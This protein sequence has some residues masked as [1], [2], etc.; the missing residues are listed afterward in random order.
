MDFRHFDEPE[1]GTSHLNGLKNRILN[2]IL[3]ATIPLGILS[4]VFAY[5]RDSKRVF[6]L[7]TE[8]ALENL[9]II[10]FFIFVFLIR[11]KIG[12]ELKIAIISALLFLYGLRALFHIGSLSTP[13]ILISIS[14]LV[15]QLN[16]G[17]KWLLIAFSLAVFLIILISTGILNHDVYSTIDYNLILGSKMHWATDIT[18][19]VFLGGV[20]IFGIGSY[21]DEIKNILNLINLKNRE[22]K[23]EIDQR[24]K[25]E[26]ELAITSRKYR[27]LFESS[28]DGVILLDSDLKILEANHVVYEAIGYTSE[29]VG[30][31]NI[32]DFID[33][34]YRAAMISRFY[35]LL[36]GERQPLTQ[37]VFISKS[38]EKV[39]IEIS[40]NLIIGDNG[41]HNILSTIR[42]TTS[43]KME[44]D[45]R[46]DA[47]LQ[48]EENERERF[49]KDL[50]DDL[51]PLFST[52]KLYVE[53]LASGESDAKKLTIMKKLSEIVDSGVKQI[54]EVSHN[55][56]PYLLKEKGLREAIEIS[57]R[58]IR[59]FAPIEIE[60]TF[61]TLN[62]S[63]KLHE[64]MDILIYR[65]FQ[66]LMNNA[67]K[68]SGATKISINV[69]IEPDVLYFMFADNGKGFN[70]DEVSKARTGIGLKNIMNRIHSRN[71]EITFSFQD[72]MKTEIRIPL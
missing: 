72:I 41:Q 42:D 53:T 51:G 44:E 19:L 55:L 20:I 54:R 49:S 62:E 8:F 43:R 59:E 5:L 70:A 9:G 56:S 38:G 24:E 65:V 14:L 6:A 37:I 46:F 11:K 71:G 25:Y 52:V 2:N 60:F 39:P 69:H 33:K 23:S 3:L 57:I 31:L 1:F 35:K 29:E 30:N 50:H 67:I 40:S 28:Q 27:L 10:L 18:A 34:Q 26:V 45:L 12:I 66:E 63:I 7:T 68:H 15:L 21:H 58:R 64:N 16:V 36:A 22:L 48:A 32:L 17:R 47:M 4:T 13:Y 61:F